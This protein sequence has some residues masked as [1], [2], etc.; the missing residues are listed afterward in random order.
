MGAG[1]TSQ[2]VT[3]T[4]TGLERNGSPEPRISP[5]I[6]GRELGTDNETAPQVWLVN[7]AEKSRGKKLS[8]MWQ[9]H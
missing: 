3:F 8:F 7:G 4:S 9:I 5:G 6:R 1:G 2:P